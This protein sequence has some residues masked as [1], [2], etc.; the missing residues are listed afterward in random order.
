MFEIRVALVAALLALSTAVPHVAS[1]Q[2]SRADASVEY[3][4]LHDHTGDLTYAAGWSVSLAGHIIPR[5]AL[6]A[7]WTTHSRSTPDTAT[8]P[9][10]VVEERV[11]SLQ[12]GPRLTLSFGKVRPYL[13]FLAG[14]SR[15]EI[16]ASG[17][18]YGWQGQTRLS[19][20][21]GLGADVAFNNWFALRGG[22]DLRFASYQETDC[23][24]CLPTTKW[25]KEIRA[26]TGLV[27]NL[28]PRD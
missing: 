17:S 3:N 18:A 10:S 24:G 26:H 22:I 21:P 8:V 23:G 20:Q 19:L 28:F 6:A 15:H 1:A 5:L 16:R 25:R 11:R 27:V 13:Q 9:V 2:E 12:A 14:E 7:E 4:Y